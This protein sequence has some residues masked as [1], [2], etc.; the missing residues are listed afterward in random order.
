MKLYE[1]HNVNE[2]ECITLH[3]DKYIS[4]ERIFSFLATVLHM[5]YIYTISDD[6]VSV[7]Q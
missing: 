3:R 2:N 1:L 6:S 5:E 7:L 4:C